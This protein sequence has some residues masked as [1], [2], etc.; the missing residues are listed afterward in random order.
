M[1][2]IRKAEP[3]DAQLLARAILTATR[4]HVRRGW[5]DIALSQSEDECLH[6]LQLLTTVRSKSQWHYSRFWIAEEGTRP[7]A[8]LSAARAADAYPKA[9]AAILEALKSSGASEAE[10]AAFWK[11]G[12][13]LFACT[14][15]PADDALVIE[16]SATLPE[17]R[18]RGYTS[19]LL[20]RVFEEGRTQRLK[21]AFITCFIGNQL[22]EKAYERAGFRFVHERRDANFEAVAGAPGIRQFVRPL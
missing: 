11:R 21:E 18:R 4:S 2:H 12:Q 15:R 10:R 7:A 19:L 16:V 20:E 22:A 6:F 3:D 14:A 5:F 9:M 13:Y 1:R 17:F 8:V